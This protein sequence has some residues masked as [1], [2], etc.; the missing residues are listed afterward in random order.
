MFIGLYTIGEVLPRVN[1][2]EDPTWRRGIACYVLGG[3]AVGVVA[4]LM[5]PLAR[6]W[7]GSVFIEAVGGAIV[8]C[9]FAIGWSGRNFYNIDN[10]IITLVFVVAGAFVGPLL[11]ARLRALPN[12]NPP[13]L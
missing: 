6:W 3:A 12:W 7:P 13:E 5:R 8:G 2:V 1:P 11:R 9:V 4:G 10:A